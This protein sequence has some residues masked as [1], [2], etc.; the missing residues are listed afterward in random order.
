M[1]RKLAQTVLD[2]EEHRALVKLAKK[3][4]LTIKDAL[5]E[6]AVRWT[7][8]ESGINPKD[9]IFDIALGRRKAQDWGK[10]TERVA[11]DHDRFLYVPVE[12]LTELRGAFKTREKLVREAIRE[13]EAEH[14][15]EARS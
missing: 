9:P 11:I 6:A 8:E 2:A 3:K 14:G 10:G 12:S 4:G 15:K 7:S 13:L 1:Q 5:R